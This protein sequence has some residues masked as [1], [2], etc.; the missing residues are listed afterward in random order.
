MSSERAWLKAAEIP[1]PEFTSKGSC[2]R[3]D[4]LRELDFLVKDIGTADRLLDSRVR[5]RVTRIRSLVATLVPKPSPEHVCDH[6]YT[7][8]VWCQL[9]FKSLD[10]LNEHRR[11]VHHE[12]AA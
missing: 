12:G 4:L 8:D 3:T 11:V 1:P 2:S 5:R 7:D 9:S 10:A 6:F